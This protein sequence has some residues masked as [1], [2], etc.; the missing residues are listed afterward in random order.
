[1][2]FIAASYVTAEQRTAATL[3]AVKQ[4]S[5]CISQCSYP[6]LSRCRCTGWTWTTCRSHKRLC[7][8]RCMYLRSARTAS[9]HTL[10]SASLVSCRRCLPASAPC[11]MSSTGR[12]RTIALC[13]RGP[14]GRG[15][16]CEPCD[17]LQVVCRHRA[18]CCTTQHAVSC[19]LPCA[20]DHSGTKA[21]A[22]PGNLRDHR[23]A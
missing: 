5:C 12:N 11:C 16:R 23:G 19:V 13:T 3:E 22:A 14:A 7:R 4:Q 9:L 8:Y 17:H 15:C 2:Q 6:L 1:M 18:D 20:A 21:E 10:A